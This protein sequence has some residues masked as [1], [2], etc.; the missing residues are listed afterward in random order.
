M[1]I[2]N[3]PPKRTRKSSNRIENKQKVNKRNRPAQA[4]DDVSNLQGLTDI[5]DAD[6]SRIRKTNEVPPRVSVFDTFQVLLG[7]QQTCCTIIFQRLCREHEAVLTLC[8]NW[9]FPGERQRPT[10]VADAR[11]IVQII[12]L[13]PCRAAAP[14]RAKAADVLVRYLG[15]DPSPHPPKR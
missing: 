1:C 10:P 13:L 8:K 9:K 11:G 7:I 2:A 12:M 5:T 3:M 4:A 14:V 6:A 15:G